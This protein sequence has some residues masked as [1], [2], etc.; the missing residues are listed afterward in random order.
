M[1]AGRQSRAGGTAYEI[2]GRRAP[3]VLVH[4]LGMTRAMWEGQWPVLTGQFR[5]LRYDL[6]GHG[7]SDK[8]EGPYSL[9][10]FVAQL[11]ALLDHLAIDRCALVGFSLGGMIV[12]AFTLAQPQRVGALAILNSPH[13]RS[14]AERTAVAARVAEAAR[15]GPEATVEAAL[16]R[17]FTEDFAA[18]SPA[19]LERVR[20]WILAN[21]RQ[22][23]PAVYRVLAESDGELAEAIS[24]I[25]C[26]TLVMT[27]EEDPGNTPA[28]A[29]AM[30]ALIPGA[31]VEIL[32]GLRHL[33][34]IEDPEAVNARLLT[35]LGAADGHGAPGDA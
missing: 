28:M 22:I 10:R 33:A 1:S 24:A 6:L 15:G 20:R 31:R 12:R 27:G 4:G 14:A 23:Y 21:D 34:L 8:P 26:P 9:S 30:A 2:A 11:E 13:A 19:V 35:F 32:P 17:W 7:E 5:T 25:A 18:R 3:V 16:K 29:R